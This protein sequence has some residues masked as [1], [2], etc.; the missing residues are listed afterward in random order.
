M[1]Y[2][3]EAAPLYEDETLDHEVEFRSALHA[4]LRDNRCLVY[5]GWHHPVPMLDF[6]SNVFS[7]IIVVEAWAANVWRAQAAHPHVRLV[8]ADV[9]SFQLPLTEGKVAIVWQQGPEHLEKRQAIDLIEAWK[10]QAHTIILEAPNGWREQGEIDGNPFET[11]LS[12]WSLE[13]F[14]NL[15]FRARL[16]MN[17]E[18]TGSIIGYWQPTG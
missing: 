13:D 9:R 14:L 8:H 4:A 3:F 15:E 11:H 6:Y 5:I 1:S 10:T 7:S 12:A 17:P 16:F 18:A 2:Q